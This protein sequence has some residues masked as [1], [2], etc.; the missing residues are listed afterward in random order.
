[1]NMKF[2][3]AKTAVDMNLSKNEGAETN[4]HE[5]S[6]YK[7]KTVQKILVETPVWGM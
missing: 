1:M 3:K 7:T 6:N 2:P 4:E 5:S